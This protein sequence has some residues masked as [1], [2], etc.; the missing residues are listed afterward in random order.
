MARVATTIVSAAA[1]IAT[2]ADHPRAQAQSDRASPP[3]RAVDHFEIAPP[4]APRAPHRSVPVIRGMAAISIVTAMEWAANEAPS[5]TE[6]P[7]EN[8]RRDFRR[9]HSILVRPLDGVSVRSDRNCVSQYPY[10]HR[11]AG[12]QN[13]PLIFSL[14]PNRS[15]R[16]SGQ[17]C[18]PSTS[19]LPAISRASN[20]R[21]RS[22]VEPAV[23][24][25]PS[26]VSI[27]LECAATGAWL[28]SG[29][30]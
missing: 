21:S 5:Q 14:F 3:C 19:V 24:E 17:R 8:P 11:A 13:P 23:M 7:S 20:A 12:H 2:A 18:R 27:L 16:R 29:S 6:I 28:K 10:A 25:R 22:I 30:D 15:R 4:R 9:R 1:I 26:M